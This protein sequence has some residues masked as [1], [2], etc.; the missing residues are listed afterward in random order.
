[1]KKLLTTIVAGLM[2]LGMESPTF[3]QSTTTSRLPENTAPTAADNLY[4][5]HGGGHLGTGCPGTTTTSPPCT[6]MRMTLGDIGAFLLMNSYISL[7]QF[8]PSGTVPCSSTANDD[9]AW[10]GAYAY[11]VAKGGAYIFV[12]PGLCYH[13]ATGLL[14]AN[15]SG[16]VG[17]PGS[18]M[19]TQTRGSSSSATT[20]MITLDNAFDT[21]WLISGLVLNG[22]WTYGRSP[23]SSNPESDP[24]LDSEHGIVIN[25]AFAGVNDAQYMANNPTGTNLP[26]GRILNTRVANFGGHC[27]S[28]TGEGSNIYDGL[29]AYGCGGNDGYI[30]T[31]DNHINHV[32]FG[33]SGRSG[34]LFTGSGSENEVSGKVW[35]SGFRKIANDGSGLTLQQYAGSNTWNGIIQDTQCDAIYDSGGQNMFRGSVGW[36]YQTNSALCSN[37]AIY[38]AGAGAS[39]P[40]VDITASSNSTTW[41]NVTYLVNDSANSLTKGQL[42]FGEVGFASDSTSIWN[43]A[44]FGGTLDFT[45]LITV[46][47][48]Q[49]GWRGLI[50]GPNYNNTGTLLS[51]TVGDT[52]QGGPIGL[53]IYASSNYAEITAGT[54]GLCFRSSTF[55]QPCA[56]TIS[57]TGAATY[58]I[59]GSDVAL[60]TAAAASTGTSGAT[61]PLLNGVNIWSST[62]SFSAAIKSPA[63]IA[64]GSAPTASGTCSISNLYGG[65]TAGAFIT[66]TCTGTTI[67]FTFASTANNGWVCTAQNLT[68]PTR[69][70]TLQTYSTTTVSF[71]ANT[72]SGDIIAYSCKGF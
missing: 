29:V 15:K 38:K 63:E 46:N 67:T 68:N 61:V 33:P 5:E 24:W 17:I 12:P 11:M 56:I 32:D 57:S 26:T 20:A 53:S 28:L 49:R 19:I 7:A 66:T 43:T 8:Y 35:G 18:V 30:N 59:G 69:T 42:R 40:V 72:T 27:Y 70:V 13:T 22:N 34:M 36:S 9:A 65:N 51:W 16:Y 71:T 55:S 1:M 47:G 6:S 21:N 60:G 64:T 58:N 44:W 62:Q 48:V 3:S 25:N 2:T 23:Y 4:V 14:I 45:N 50:A 39:A 54:G 41:P 31:Y 52:S 10:A 37:L